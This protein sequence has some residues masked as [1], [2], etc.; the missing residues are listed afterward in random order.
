MQK[1]N[2][3]YEKAYQFA[4]RV[5]KAYQ[6]LSKEKKELIIDH[7]RIDHWRIDDKKLPENSLSQSAKT[8]NVYFG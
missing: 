4:I 5:V 2:V 1:K 3:V 6:F 8:S 7:W